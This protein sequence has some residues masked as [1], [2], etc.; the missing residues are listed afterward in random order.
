[1]SVLAVL[2]VSCANRGVGPQGGPID[3]IPPIPVKEWP[4]N[5]MLNFM[6]KD[7]KIEITF[8]E[9]IQLD[10]VSKNV[11]ISPPQQ[12][13]PEV[14][15]FGK[16]VT[17]IFDAPLQDS[18]T[19][20]IDFGN[21][22]CDY[23]EKVP[24]QGYSLSFSTCNWIDS[25]EVCGYLVNAEDL[26]P[27]SGIVVGIQRQLEDSAF[28]T[29]PFTR[30]TK[31][32]EMGWFQVKNVAAASYRLY[33][34]NDVS[35]DYVY[36]PGEDLAFLDT[37]I[38]IHPMDSTQVDSTIH[39]L[40]Y[41]KENK[42]RSYFQRCYREQ[43]H[44]FRLQ[45]SAPQDTL[46]IIRSLRPSDLDSTKSDSTWVDWMNYALIQPSLKGDTIMVWL[47][48]SAAISQD[49]ILIEMRY[50]KSDSLYE[51]FWQTDTIRAIY[52]APRISDKAKA[53][54]EKKK[55]VLTYKSNGKKG[56]DIYNPLTITFETPIHSLNEQGI[57][58]W[59]KIDTVYH[60]LPLSIHPLD[61]F[62]MTYVIEYAWEAE[63]L[64][65]CRID[66]A[67][68]ADVYGT[69]NEAS[70]IQMK[71]KS[72]DEYSTLRIKLVQYTEHV[73]VQLLDEKDVVLKEIAMQEDGAFFEYLSPKSY[74]VR[75]YIDANED[76]QWTT[77]DWLTKRQPE[78]VYYFPSK[79]TL[80]ANWDF[81]EEFDYLAL[82]Q[83]DSK[84]HELLQDASAKKK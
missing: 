42:R 20:T 49:S 75:M 1:M 62:Y 46:P 83:L 15:V 37:T 72:M 84:P 26:N 70:K 39:V 3:S 63:G 27:V 38:T 25:L 41:F 80:R 61:S 21:A 6:P 77:G 47:T 79:L 4:T 57:S 53:K 30:V 73:R 64:Y 52:R 78:P 43:A 10:D 14:K 68:F 35:R 82:P 17:L 13:P 5:G 58:L 44:V 32:N 65:E 56:F 34:L 76:G 12:R 18:T 69:V 16:K 81:E 45:F 9:Y 23:H 48:D 11:L 8:D 31:T 50:M 40:W 67:A 2:L 28:E 24:L 19:Y 71:V 66:S 29:L 33:A 55:S 22:I 36:Q 59:Q 7:K 51:L 74:Y 60:P 54:M